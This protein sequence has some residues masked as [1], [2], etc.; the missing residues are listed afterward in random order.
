MKKLELTPA[1]ET[2]KEEIP[3][4]PVPKQTFDDFDDVIAQV[5]KNPVPAFSQELL[6]FDYEWLHYLTLSCIYFPPK[7]KS[8]QEIPPYP[9]LKYHQKQSYLPQYDSNIIF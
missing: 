1:T 4:Y 3:K 5:K 6:E 2:M 8:Y 7:I 9:Q